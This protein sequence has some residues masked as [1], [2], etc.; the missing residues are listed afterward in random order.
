MRSR[1]I[2]ELDDTG[3][4]DRKRQERDHFIDEVISGVGCTV[5]RAQ[6]ITEQTRA[7]N[8]IRIILK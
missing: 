5:I 4:N 1:L 2:V 6:Y 8:I 7:V 3:H